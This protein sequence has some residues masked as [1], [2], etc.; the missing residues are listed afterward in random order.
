M[1]RCHLQ[2][3]F[4]SGVQASE[5]YCT[6][7]P[8][9]LS[10][11]FTASAW[12]PKTASTI[13]CK[14]RHSSALSSSMWC[15]RSS[16]RCIIGRQDETRYVV[17]VLNCM[18]CHWK[19]EKV[20]CEFSVDMGYENVFWSCWF[21]RQQSPYYYAS[22]MSLCHFASRDIGMTITMRRLADWRG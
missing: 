13:G 5:I 17:V 14:S 6:S 21:W 16:N 15:A 3:T 12:F 8:V 4:T 19:D 11:H 20:R 9:L 22:G 7:K 10:K 2:Q 1:Y 18:L